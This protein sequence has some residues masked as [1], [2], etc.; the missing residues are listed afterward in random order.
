MCDVLNKRV[1]SGPGYEEFA[2]KPG[3][4]GYEAGTLPGYDTQADQNVIY[5]I[6]SKA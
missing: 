5:K 2:V 6:I 4:T 3:N 1:K